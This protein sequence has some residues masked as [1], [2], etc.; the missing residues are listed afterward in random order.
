MS[1]DFQI[2][3]LASYRMIVISE[4]NPCSDT[5]LISGD[6]EEDINSSTVYGIKPTAVG[7]YEGTPNFRTIVTF[8]TPSWTEN[9]YNGRLLLTLTGPYAGKCYY[10]IDTTTTQ[11]YI[12]V[13]STTERDEITTSTYYTIVHTASTMYAKCVADHKSCIALTMEDYSVS[14]GSP[15][16]PK[17][18]AGHYT[19]KIGTGKYGQSVKFSKLMLYDRTPA[20]ML[21]LSNQVT[22][23]FFRWHRMDENHALYL[24]ISGEYLDTVSG[25]TYTVNKDFYYETEVDGVI[26]CGRGYMKGFPML[27]NEQISFTD[28]FSFDFVEAWDQN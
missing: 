8:G 17:S 19:M 15:E 2:D 1:M 4:I 16:T 23:L 20:K 5:C 10:I 12:S 14:G 22:Q 11:L 27:A 3:N 26:L 18:Y 9:A 7:A 24:I 25:R 13:G 21:Y 6:T 28:E